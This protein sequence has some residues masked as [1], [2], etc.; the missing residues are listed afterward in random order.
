[1]SILKRGEGGVEDLLLRGGEKGR[2]GEQLC[3][4]DTEGHWG[5]INGLTLI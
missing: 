3:N 5:K 4:K 2:G 1:M